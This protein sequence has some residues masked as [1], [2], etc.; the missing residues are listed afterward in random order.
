M[1]RRQTIIDIL[2]TLRKSEFAHNNKWK[3]RAYTNV[4][5]QLKQMTEP[6][7]KMDDLKDIKGIG[8]KIK[9]KI[10]EILTTGD[11]PK[12][13]EIGKEVDVINNLTRVFGIGPV[14]A[15]E[16]YT[17]HGVEKVED[18]EHKRELLTDKQII[19]L[20][21]YK[22]FELRIKRSE[23]DKHADII[24]TTIQNLYPDLLVEV[25][26]S[27][28]R[29]IADSGDIDVLITHRDD[30]DNYSI[31][32]DG[33]IKHLSDGGYITDV[34]AQGKKKFNGVCRLKRHKYHR[35]LDIMYT[36][37][38]EWAFALLYFTGD[39]NFNI[40]FRKLALDNH[41]SMNEYGFKHTR[42]EHKMSL[43]KV[44][45]DERAVFEYLGV[46]Y[47][48]PEDRN[49]RVVFRPLVKSNLPSS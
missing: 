47:I 9:L 21:Y 24:K 2:E 16:L 44:F 48:P 13:H 40:L 31:Y 32:F 42:G 22:D 25:M 20:K 41:L 11:L 43:D 26:G 33:I 27:Y 4:I 3:V 34:F 5:N 18:L 19:G 30:P 7:T 17:T 1:D 39:Q 49:G 10:E 8:E 14:R 6:V 45:E 37:K 12:A 23:M 15:K 29:G 28:R 38:K 36:R 46:E 35:R